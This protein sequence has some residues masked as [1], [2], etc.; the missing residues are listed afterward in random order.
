M[1]KVVRRWG[2]CWCGFWVRDM[3]PLRGS[4]HDAAARLGTWRRCAARGMF[5]EVAI[6]D[7]GAEAP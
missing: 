5:P 4:R 7:C 3:P 1:S 2:M 6:L